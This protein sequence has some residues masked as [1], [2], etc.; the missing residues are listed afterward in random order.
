MSGLRRAA[1]FT[2]A[3]LLAAPAY[4]DNTADEAD[5]AFRRGV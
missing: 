4:A 3:I 1:L 2:L 5:L